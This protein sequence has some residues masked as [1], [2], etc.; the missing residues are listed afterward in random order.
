MSEKNTPKKGY[1]LIAYRYDYA[2]TEQVVEFYNDSQVEDLEKQIR[3]LLSRE[4][5]PFKEK[6]IRVILGV[7]I[8]FMVTKDIV[9]EVK[10]HVK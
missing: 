4:H 7:Q 1:H 10:I 2:E 9:T 6:D 3:G 5:D 8:P